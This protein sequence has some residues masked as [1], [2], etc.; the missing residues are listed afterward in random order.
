VSP[1]RRALGRW[2][3]LIDNQCGAA[4]V[5]AIVVLVSLTALALALLAV[6]GQEPQIS[7]NHVDMVRARYLAEAGVEHALA[8]LAANVGSWSVYLADATCAVGAVMA[9][10]TLPGLPQAYGE[11]TVRVRNDCE[12]GDIRVTGVPPEPPSNAA[13]DTNGTVI[14][15]S[16]GGIGPT[17]H[18]VTVVVSAND[19]PTPR[20]SGQSVASALVTARSWSDQ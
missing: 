9:R 13:S 5:L 19:Q 10:A 15:A 7:R 6:G 17:T 20:Q 4:L 12:P 2:P 16:T 11:F 8:T 3:A 14:V 1:R 18:T